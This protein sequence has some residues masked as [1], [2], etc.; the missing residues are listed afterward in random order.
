MAVLLRPYDL[1]LTRPHEHT[2][3]RL[4]MKVCY[5]IDKSVVPALGLKELYADPF[6]LGERGGAV[7]ADN[8]SSSGDF[9]E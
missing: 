3:V 5:T 4:A 8:A 2:V 1:D 6:A 9:Y 7:E